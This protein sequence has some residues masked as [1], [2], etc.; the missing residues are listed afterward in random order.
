[1]RRQVSWRLVALLASVA[2]V[3]A[4]ALVDSTH[5]ARGQYADLQRLEA[6]RWQLQEDYSR[7]LLEASTL[8]S[9]HRVVEVSAGE[10]GMI[11]PP[12]ET[13]RVVER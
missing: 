10:L 9:P 13:L 8:A 3:S 7:L 1:M 4:L 5:R 2:L 12:L 11:P 6:E